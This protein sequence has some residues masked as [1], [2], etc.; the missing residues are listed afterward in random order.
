MENG[1]H[2]PETIQEKVERQLFHLKTLYDVSRELLGEVDVGK[3]LK[4]F[5]LMTTG[6]FGVI[7]GFLVIREQATGEISHLASVGFKDDLLPMFSGKDAV[8]LFDRGHCGC[9]TVDEGAPG[10]EGADNF[11]PSIVCKLPFKVDDS[12]TGLLGLGPKIVGGLYSDEDKDIL[13]TLVNNLAITI[14]S[15]RYAEALESAYAE[16]SSLNRAKSKMIDHLSHELKTPMAV[17]Q[18]ALNMFGKKLKDVPEDKWKKSHERAQRAVER[19]FE[20][21]YEVEDIMEGKAFKA[22]GFLNKMLDVCA[23]EL[24]M[25]L[26]ERSGEGPVVDWLRDRIEEIFGSRECV[27][28]KIHLSRL[29]EDTLS[30]IRPFFSHRKIK[31]GLE[32]DENDLVYLPQDPIKKVVK[33]LVKNA[34]ENTPDGGSVFVRVRTSD[35]GLVMEVEDTGIGIIEEHRDRILEGFF[36]TQETSAYSSKRPFD[37]NAGG[38]GADLLRTRIFSERY[39]FSLKLTSSRCRF[40]PTAYD[41]CPGRI[42]NCEACSTPEDCRKSGGTTFEVVF[43][44]SP[45]E[46]R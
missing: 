46:E 13:L 35:A 36:H 20:V 23:D 25:L 34:V 39:G 43:P 44:P 5:L 12:C 16:V 29:V 7:E 9:R 22:Y 27:P 40:L 31:I 18:A 33:G 14:K 2:N 45:G 10:G 24:E 32:T 42:S 8:L 15:A 38:K 21:Q 6:N 37:F 3:V 26:S 4:N 41:V 1:I 19:L 11:P 17:L 28:E 30:G